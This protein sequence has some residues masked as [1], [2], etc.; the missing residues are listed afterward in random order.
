MTIGVV[1][2][3]ADGV[4]QRTAGDWR[5]KF[6]AMLDDP[7]NLDAFVAD[8]FAAERPCLTGAI[9]FPTQLGEVLQR[10]RSR[11]TVEQALSVWTNIE[12]DRGVLE[13]VSAL[14]RA[15][16]FCCLASNQQ[17]HRAGYMSAELGYRSVFD[18][19][20]YSCRVGHAKPDPA[21]FQHILG[22]LQLAP[23]QALF[24]DD[25]EPNII[26]A[27]RVGIPS[28]HFAANAGANALSEHLSAHDI[29]VG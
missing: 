26:S 28:V 15:N 24:I 3:D 6:S 17:A 20:F 2:F 7:T 10:W 9:D 18:R 25:V 13:L 12:V 21:Y 27:R 16:V 8:V 29:R 14:R 22:E 5:D 19:E 4:I 1:L 11:T 23:E